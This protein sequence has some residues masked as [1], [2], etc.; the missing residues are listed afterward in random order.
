[1]I[2][3]STSTVAPGAAVRLRTSTTPV[4]LAPPRGARVAGVGARGHRD[5]RERAG[6]E[7]GA[8]SFS[9]IELVVDREAVSGA[10]LWFTIRTR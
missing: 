3:N 9:A 6:L 4:P 10:A 5:Q 8:G 1:M 7:R 2:S